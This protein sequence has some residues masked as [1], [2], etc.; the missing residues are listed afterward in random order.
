MKVSELAEY[1]TK[2]RFPIRSIKRVYKK[3]TKVHMVKLAPEDSPD[4]EK[5][6]NYSYTWTTSFLYSILKNPMYYGEYYYG[7]SAV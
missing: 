6:Q 1:L 7:K 5:T 4:A 3:S 2:E